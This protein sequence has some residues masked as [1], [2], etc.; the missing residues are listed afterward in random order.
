MA[1]PRESHLPGAGK[2][3]QGSREGG[4]LGVSK[5]GW[6]TCLARHPHVSPGR[7]SSE[8]GLLRLG[9]SNSQQTPAPSMAQPVF[10]G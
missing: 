4:G 6:Q 3:L 1:G 10:L 9:C 7:L 2:E 8:G 5:A